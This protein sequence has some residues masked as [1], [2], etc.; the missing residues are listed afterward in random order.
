MDR[1][2]LGVCLLGVLALAGCGNR[3][4]APVQA[5]SLAS[6]GSRAQPE[7]FT[8]VAFTPP[9]FALQVGAFEQRAR[10]EALAASLSDQYQVGVLV[11]PA[12]VHGKALYRVR[13]LVGTKPEAEA[14]AAD[15]G[16]DAPKTWIVALR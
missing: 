4:S 9:R 5:S 10:A 6:G 15:L 8:P 3:S 7:E 1:R 11:A 12:K 14:L 16:R 13:I 2:V